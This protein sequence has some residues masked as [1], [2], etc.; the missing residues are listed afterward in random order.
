MTNDLPTMI[1][2]RTRVAFA[3]DHRHQYTAPDKILQHQVVARGS[4]HL[5]TA[6]S[7][8][9]DMT[10]PH[11]KAFLE[12]PPGT[13]YGHSK[14]T[15]NKGQLLSTVCGGKHPKPNKGIITH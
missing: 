7:T 6:V 5:D 11:R 12:P 3:G 9:A 4:V 2:T 13:K 10:S 15:S 14:G 1:V 8:C